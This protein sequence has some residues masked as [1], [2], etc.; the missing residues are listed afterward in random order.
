MRPVSLFFCL[1]LALF[2]AGCSLTD[3]EEI[4]ES[5]VLSIPDDA[6]P[7]PVK[8][9]SV[10]LS[11]P[12][13]THLGSISPRN[14]F[15]CAFPWG[16][17]T[18]SDVTRHMERSE[19]KEAFET[20]LETQGYD[21]AGRSHIMFDADDD[22]ARSVYRIGA[23]IT[24]IK[25]D[26]CHETGTFFGF[27]TEGYSG[28]TMMV[29]EWTIYDNLRKT[30]A[31]KTTT[32]GYSKLRWANQEGIGLLLDDAF[33]SASHNL[34][35]DKG[36]HDLIVFGTKPDWRHKQDKKTEHRLFDPQEK[37]AIV[38]IP[39]FKTTAQDRMD[40]LRKAS[41]LI[42]TGN[43]H[44]SGFFITKDGHILTNAH[45]TGDA[46]RVRIVTEQKKHKLIGE[47]LRVDKVRDVALIKLDTLPDAYGVTVLPIR[48]TVP[49]V[50]KDIYAIGAPVYAKRLQD[51][52]TKGIV[53]AYRPDD[54]W[55]HV[56]YIQGDVTIHP[57]NSGGPLL[58]EAGN[59]IGLSVA[60]FTDDEGAALSGLNLFVPIA[61][62][63]KALDIEY[64]QQ[65]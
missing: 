8:F 60:G 19:M 63:L 35:A 28:E 51:T 42:E 26:F 9:S 1:A 58:D 64:E 53:S 22:E 43:G 32:K 39:L 5:P 30:T 47:V 57:G 18:R 49:G 33:A 27:S 17:M 48:S 15:V 4:K 38:S 6:A 10:K 11:I 3:V 36:F 13:G 24:D 23:R 7:S 65:K 25:G 50:G 44:G 59:I 29:V 46:K 21:V 31:Y 52:V 40:V 45:V 14:P 62:A 37:V 55:S 2:F 12:R 61:E 41:V 54:R 16:D 56:S 34:G 20:T